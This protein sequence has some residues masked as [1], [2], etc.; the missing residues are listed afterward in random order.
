MSDEQASRAGSMF[1]PYHLKRL[2]GRGGMGEVYEAEH[3]VKEWTVAV[4]LLSESFSRDPVFRERMKREARTAGRLQ[5]PHVVPVHDY[6]EIDG[7]IFLEMR[8]VEGTDLDSVLKRFGPLT[9]PRAVAVITQI[10]SAL[11]AAHAAGVMHRDVKPQNILVTADDFAYLVDFGIASA[12]TDEKLT[13]LGT[14]VGTWKYMAPERFSDAEVTYRADIYALACVLFECL[15]GAP[16]Y[17]A[18][19]AGMLVSA[20]MMDPI[21]APSQRRPD[22]PKAFDAVIARGMAKRPEDRYASA[23]DLALAA[24]QALSHPDQ[25]RAATILRRSQEAALPTAVNPDPRLNTAPPPRPYQPAF[26]TPPPSPPRAPYYQGAS[27]NW[28]GPPPQ[29]ANAAPWGQPPPRPRRNVWL[30]VA[31]VAAVFVLLGGGLGI[32]LVTRPDPEPPTPAPLE[33]DRLSALLLGPSDINTVMGSSTMQPGKPI[34]STDH[35]SVTVSTPDCQGALYTTQ[36]PVYAGTGY[37]SVSGLV[38]SEPGDNYDHW[39]NQAVVLFPSADKAKSFLENSAEKWKGCAGKTVTVTNK[40]KTYRWTFAQVQGSPPKIT[41]MDT[42]EG[43][44]GWE[45]QRALT[46]AN[47]V[48]V[49]INACGYHISDQGAQIAD[50]IAARIA[51]E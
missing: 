7:Q 17:R 44:D 27:A 38:S 29:F 31:A 36:D 42:Q 33:A 47:N 49:D 24:K 18:D 6:G 32:W 28:G 9:P 39:V 19:S 12:T 46:V 45:C 13:Q 8:L 40:S 50:K 41:L 22:I 30:I 10:A 51:D 14:A 16:P 2:L 20:H 15:T 5:E 1:G 37:T 25:D 21:P 11:D 26:N 35:S 43:A 34:T 23:G 3:T 48:I 4:K